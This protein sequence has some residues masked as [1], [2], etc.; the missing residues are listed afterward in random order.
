M[1]FFT[2]DYISV[3]FTDFGHRGAVPLADVRNLD[4]KFVKVECFFELVSS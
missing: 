1:E 3:F 2:K 4:E